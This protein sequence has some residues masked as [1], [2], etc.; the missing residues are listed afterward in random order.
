MNTFNGTDGFS[1]TGDSTRLSNCGGWCG[2]HCY[3]RRGDLP[4]VNLAVTTDNANDSFTLGSG[5]DTIANAGGN[6][7][8][9]AGGSGTDTLAV[10]N[11]DLDASADT[12]TGIEKITLTEDEDITLTAAQVTANSLTA[13]TGTNGGNAELLG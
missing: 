4:E 3:C 8:K 12:V 5:D 11:A 2:E 9:A 7:L 13:V 10:F 1:T 6:L